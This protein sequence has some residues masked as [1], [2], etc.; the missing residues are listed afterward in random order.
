MKTETS[1]GDARESKKARSYLM[2]SG[3]IGLK[4]ANRTH[5]KIEYLNSLIELTKNFYNIGLD[6]SKIIRCV[7]NDIN[8]DFGYPLKFAEEEVINKAKETLKDFGFTNFERMSEE[9]L[10][11]KAEKYNSVDDK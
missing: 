4:E 1:Q 3:V 9:E 10:R 5:E 7:C 8:D 11:K 6:V 2:E